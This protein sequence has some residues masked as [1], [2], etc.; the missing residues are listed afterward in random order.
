MPRNTDK[1]FVVRDNR[2]PKYLKVYNEF[3]DRFGSVIGPYGLAVYVALC[4][5][6]DAD[7]SACWPSY[8][9][10]AKGTGMSRRQVIREVAKMEQLRIIA[11]E[12]N[13]HTSNVFVLLDTSDTQS[14]LPSDTQSPPSDRKSPK[15]SPSN[16]TIHHRSNKNIDRPS[17]RPPADVDPL[18]RP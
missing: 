4:R 3:Y 1:S 18:T 5:Y 12:R 8:G 15:Q 2:G 9:T 13:H 11:I 14:P 10:I 16:K 7:S 17:F 6:I